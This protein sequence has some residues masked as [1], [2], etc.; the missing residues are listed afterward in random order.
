MLEIETSEANDDVDAPELLEPCKTK[1]L[2]PGGSSNVLILAYVL[3]A[4]GRRGLRDAL[5][6]R[7]G[8]GE[9]HPHQKLTSSASWSSA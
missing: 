1:R 9:K 6:Q 3:S 7:K 2:Y 4:V 8:E 5:G